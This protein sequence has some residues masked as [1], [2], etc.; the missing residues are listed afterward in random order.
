MDANIKRVLTAI[1]ELEGLL[2]VVKNRDVSNRGLIDELIREKADQ[3]SSIVNELYTGSYDDEEIAESAEFEEFEDADE[4]VVADE[5]EP[6]SVTGEPETESVEPTSDDEAALAESVEFELHED[7]DR[8]TEEEI[9]EAKVENSVD[10][11]YVLSPEEEKYRAYMP[12]FDNVEKIVDDVEEIEDEEPV[13]NDSIDE[14]PE[15][16]D[17]VADNDDSYADEEVADEEFVDEDDEYEDDELVDDTEDDD[18]RVDEQLSR[19]LSKNL[20][21][22]F[23]LNDRFRFRRELFGNHDME[24]NETLNLV[25]AMHSYDEAEDYFYNDL[26]WDKDSPEVIDFMK[27][28]EKH[29]A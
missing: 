10:D 23:T 2:N 5:E 12:R 6:G 14:V 20:K 7:A 9:E 28:I 29:F 24:F 11:D 8:E 18:L 3:I 19:N 15:L 13:V 27:I 16:V 4:Q 25:E 17:T 1:Y 22:A 26:Q 21:K